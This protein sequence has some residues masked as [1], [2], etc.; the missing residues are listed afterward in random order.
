MQAWQFA[1]DPASASGNREN[2]DIVVG[3]K[4]FFK[5]IYVSKLCITNDERKR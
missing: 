3:K 2:D 4:V 1:G 5:H